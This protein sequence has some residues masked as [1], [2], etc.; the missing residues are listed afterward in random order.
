MEFKMSDEKNLDVKIKELNKKL[1]KILPGMHSYQ[2]LLQWIGVVV[3]VVIVLV[4]WGTFICPSDLNNNEYYF[5]F[6]TIS[7]TLLTIIAVAI[8]WGGVRLLSEE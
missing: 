1:D 2:K 8:I 4:I 3:L 6:L 7:N 5:W